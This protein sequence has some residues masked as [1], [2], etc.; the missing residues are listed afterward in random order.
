MLPVDT[1][2]R[3]RLPPM[4]SRWKTTLAAA[5]RQCRLRLIA[6]TRPAERA[7]T[8]S[9]SLADLRLP[10]NPPPLPAIANLY[11]PIAYATR[12]GGNRDATPK[13]ALE[14]RL[15]RE[16]GLIFKGSV[17]VCPV[18]A[19]ARYLAISRR[20]RLEFRVFTQGC[21]I[22]ILPHVRQIDPSRC[23]RKLQRVES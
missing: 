9:P 22:W 8:G 10:A 2:S 3:Q 17:C 1:Q 16:K 13:S 14:H 7:S 12:Q 19:L 11:R 15:P 23:D 5:G 18:L 6:V 4:I 20:N 21:K